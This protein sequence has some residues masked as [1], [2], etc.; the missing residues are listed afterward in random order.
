MVGHEGNY[1][2]DFIAKRACVDKSSI[3]GNNVG[4]RVDNC[5]DG[6]GDSMSE[7]K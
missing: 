2:R 5:G 7:G 3:E 1:R 4:W 6:W